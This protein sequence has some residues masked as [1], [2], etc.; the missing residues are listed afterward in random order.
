MENIYLLVSVLFSVLLLWWL[1]RQL[2]KYSETDWGKGWMRAMDGLV[3]LFVRKFHHARLDE[4]GLPESG[5]AVLVSNHISGLD[6]LL[7]VAAS[8]RPIRFIIATEQY[9]RFGFKWLFRA[10][11]CIPVDRTHRPERALRHARSALRR[12]EVVALFPHGTIHLDSD[13]PRKLKRGFAKLSQW[14]GAPVYSCRVE[15]VRGEG[16][17]ILAL[18]MRGEPRLKSCSAMVCDEENENACL[19]YIAECINGHKAQ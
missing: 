13:P 10:A 19:D 17:T 9:E 6:P 16:H 18:L 3:R 7:M 2:Q 5:P 8:R 1:Y 15:G 11:R 12:G 14:S 4:I